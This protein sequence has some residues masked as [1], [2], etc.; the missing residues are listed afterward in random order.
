[1]KKNLEARK[2][3]WETVKQMRDEYIVPSNGMYELPEADVQNLENIVESAY[4]EAT[5][6]ELLET[7]RKSRSKGKRALAKQLG[8]NHARVAKIEQ[9]S[10][11]ELKSLMQAAKALEYQVRVTLEPING[12]GEAISATLRV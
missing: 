5:I 1:M 10:N 8:T 9:S 11:I 6:G 12:Q 2:A 3:A 7:A 4:L